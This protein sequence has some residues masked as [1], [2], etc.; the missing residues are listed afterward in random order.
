MIELLIVIA[1][2]A[3]LASL[4]LSAMSQAKSRAHSTACANNLR[5]MQL[6]SQLYTDDNGHRM[7][8]NK[9]GMPSGY[10]Q[11]VEGA[12]VVGN[13][14]RN[15]NDE[16]LRRGTLWPY[17]GTARLYQCPGDHSTVTGQPTLRRFRSYGLNFNL[18][19]ENTTGSAIGVA[20]WFDLQGRETRVAADSSKLFGFMGVSEDSIDSGAFF[21]LFRFPPASAP[22]YWY[23]LPGQRHAKGANL[24]YLDGRVEYHRWRFVPKTKKVSGPEPP[25]NADDRRHAIWLL[26]RTPFWQWLE[27]NPAVYP[28]LLAEGAN[29]RDQ[30]SRHVPFDAPFSH[31]LI[32]R[33]SKPGSRWKTTTP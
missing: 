19:G 12:W 32:E 1:I 7:P 29:E 18:N 17:V 10:W 14:K 28:A 23:H 9:D 5:Q 21:F 33:C 4:L 25:A 24:S 3:I 20:W 31:V 13:P 27:A 2:L 16:N 26:K 30:I 15:Q 11:S 8:L 6:A 22:W